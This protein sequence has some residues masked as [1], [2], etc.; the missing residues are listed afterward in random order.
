MHER[1]LGYLLHPLPTG[2]GPDESRPIFM[3]HHNRPNRLFVD[4]IGFAAFAFLALGP[5]R[6]AHAQAPL[7]AL[8]PAY[9]NPCCA[10][11]LTMWPDLIA[12]ASSGT[13]VLHVILNPSSGP[14]ASPIDPNFVNT[15][16]VGPAVDL[17]SAGGRLYGYVATGFGSR[18][19]AAV[20]AD[21]DRYY[22]PAYWRGA[23]VLVSGIF[24]DEMTND[25]AAT[26]YYQTLDAYVKSKDIG[27]RV[28][29]NPGTSFTQ[30][31]S[32]GASGFSV[33]DYADSVDTI[34]TFENTGVAYRTGYAPPSWLAS[35]DASHFAHIIHTEASTTDMQQDI[36][37]ARN[38]KVGFVYVTDDVLPNPFDFLASYWSEEQVAIAAV[39]VPGLGALGWA[40]GIL[41]VGVC[42]TAIWAS[43]RRIPETHPSAG[44]ID[45][46]NGW[47]H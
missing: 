22:D 34:V 20:Q 26:G 33:G 14:G 10:G 36:Q 9:A 41:G 7:A 15:G 28:F 5:A 32:G 1:L 23:G 38:R 21:I 16:G 31:T 12:A 43:R 44:S 46:S 25:I 3:R 40:A 45:V 18:P 35:L 37:L 27:A 17:V 19:L 39:P 11:G 30:D 24:L 47:P 6:P 13:I 8:V 4:L 42:A 2:S 29:G